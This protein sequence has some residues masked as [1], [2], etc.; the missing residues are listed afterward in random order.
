MTPTL[1]LVLRLLQSKE[2]AEGA[3][4]VGRGMRDNPANIRVFAIRDGEE[5]SRALR[6]FFVPVLT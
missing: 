4:L 6:R 3:Q 1:S 5:R 2:L